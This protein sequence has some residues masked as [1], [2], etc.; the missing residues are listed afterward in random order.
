VIKF[1]ILLV[2]IVSNLNNCRFPQIGQSQKL[3]IKL[4]SQISNPKSQILNTEY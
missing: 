4:K 3:S 2:F 1:S